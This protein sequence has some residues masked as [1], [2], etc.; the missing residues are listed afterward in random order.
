MTSYAMDGDREKFLQ[1][2]MN[3]YV[4]K[5]VDIKMLMKAIGQMLG[6]EAGKRVGAT[7]EKS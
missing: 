7:E 5:P 1:A 3:A 4:S 2:G 6:R